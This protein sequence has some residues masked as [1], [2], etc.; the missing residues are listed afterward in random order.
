MSLVDGGD[1]S[2]SEGYFSLIGSSTSHP[3]HGKMIGFKDVGSTGA[4]KIQVAGRKYTKLTIPG[5]GV[6][7]NTLSGQRDAWNTLWALNVD[8]NTV[9]L[10]KDLLIELSEEPI[11]AI[12]TGT[13]DQIPNGI[14]DPRN[15]M[16]YTFNAEANT[17]QLITMANGV[18]ST[19]NYNL[20]II[21]GVSYNDPNTYPK[22]G[23]FYAVAVT[24]DTGSVLDQKFIDV[25]LLNANQFIITYETTKGD[26]KRKTTALENRKTTYKYSYW[27]HERLS[28]LS[29][30]DKRLIEKLRDLSTT[31]QS[32]F[33]VDGKDIN[34]GTTSQ[35]KTG[36]AML[37]DSRFFKTGNGTSRF[38]N[39]EGY[40]AKDDY[41][42][43]R[44]NTLI[45]D[46]V[47]SLRIEHFRNGRNE[48]DLQTRIRMLEYISPNEGT[49]VILKGTAPNGTEDTTTTIGELKD[50]FENTVFSIKINSD[51]QIMLGYGKSSVSLADAARLAKADL[52]SRATDMRQ[53]TPHIVSEHIAQQ[54]HFVP[55]ILS[56]DI[57]RT[58]VG[59][60]GKEKRATGNYNKGTQFF[61]AGN[62]LSLKFLEGGKVTKKSWEDG[63]DP[64]PFGGSP[65]TYFAFIRLKPET[66]V[67]WGA[68]GTGGLP[69]GTWPNEDG[70]TT[71][72]G[73][74]PGSSGGY[75]KNG[76][77]LL[78]QTIHS[79]G[80]DPIIFRLHN[81]AQV[82][83][84]SPTV[85][86]NA[87]TTTSHWSNV[88]FNNYHTM[89]LGTGANLLQHKW[90]YGETKEKATQNLSAIPFYNGSFSWSS[91]QH[92]RKEFAGFIGKTYY[93]ANIHG[94][95]YQTIGDF[96]EPGTRHMSVFPK[97]VTA[98]GI[99]IYV[100]DIE[101]RGDGGT[102]ISK[103][104]SQIFLKDVSNS[105]T[106][107]FAVGGYGKL[108]GTF[109][110]FK[111]SGNEGRM[112]FFK[113]KSGLDFQRISGF[114]HDTPGSNIGDYAYEKQAN[115]VR[116]TGW[117]PF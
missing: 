41:Y 4:F 70:S 52:V 50:L 21:E 16:T 20:S 103:T 94:N 48:G 109:M 90:A 46:R 66:S 43:F 42:V 24:S 28:I 44:F 74:S 85:A 13:S 67:D 1:T 33:T 92:R 27:T 86:N 17:L 59:E 3:E 64:L 60:D 106:L 62:Q 84:T 114:L 54:E 29:D 113:P 81:P 78:V 8:K 36:L 91:S 65:D 34:A 105:G 75:D 82:R 87:I 14:Y 115:N 110:S 55:Y 51:N 97:Q 104:T 25:T 83:N 69:G 2:D 12:S 56:G 26:T 108:S 61:A 5:T 22:T 63:N 9:I 96:T 18:R 111:I 39:R 19:H 57:Y 7:P 49:F 30:M 117:Y 77:K 15:T 95:S 37:A 76:M 93:M 10:P 58:F 88:I 11:G 6:V 35:T 23:L 98:N 68:T 112:I 102:V 71:G 53:Y 31:P 45:T 107:T 100:I 80:K 47:D 89:A 72:S 116:T 38:N 32:Y 101:Y 99:N 79:S 73:G 40:F